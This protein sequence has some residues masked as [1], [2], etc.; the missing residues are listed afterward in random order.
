MKIV[1]DSLPYISGLWVYIPLYPDS[2][3]LQLVI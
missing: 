2:L 3:L 1:D